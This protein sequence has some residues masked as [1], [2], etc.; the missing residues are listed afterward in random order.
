M[1]ALAASA[2]GHAAVLANAPFSPE[3]GQ[4][5]LIPSAPAL[6][7]RLALT[8]PADTATPEP[9][10]RR[11]AAE[12]AVAAATTAVAA[13]SSAG[14]AAN[15]P[16]AGLPAPEIYYRGREVDDRAEALNSTDVE[17]PADALS[18]RLSGNVTLRLAI[19]HLGVL[20]E[21]QVVQA[22]PPG[23]FDAAATKA[24]RTLKFK[25]AMRYGM[26]VGSIKL[27]EVPFEPD[28]NRSLR[29]GN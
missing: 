14:S 22:Q 11:E 29:C 18:A 2:F 13:S 8:Q 1:L 25:P 10:A 15:A 24:A 12:S 9:A 3:S 4:L 27:I 16:A 20:R 21:V 5:S 17:Y 7:V 19:D 6:R 26:A 28:C 23:V